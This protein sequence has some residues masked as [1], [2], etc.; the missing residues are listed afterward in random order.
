MPGRHKF[1]DIGGV[2][3]CEHCGKNES[4]LDQR[5]GVDGRLPPCPEVSDQNEATPGKDSQ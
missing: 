2:P 4:F 3:C 1:V 5:R